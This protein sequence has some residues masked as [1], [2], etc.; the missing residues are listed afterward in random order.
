[1]LWPL[2]ALLHS[3]VL[4]PAT[5][6]SASRAG[7]L[8]LRRLFGLPVPGR[9]ISLGTKSDMDIDINTDTGT[10]TSVDTDMNMDTDL[11]IDML[12]VPGSSLGASLHQ[13]A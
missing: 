1:M 4:V 12:P 6:L 3:G 11:D 2:G 5:A 10:D 9:G 13:T 7:A 8:G